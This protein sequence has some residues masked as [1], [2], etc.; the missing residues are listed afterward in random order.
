MYSNVVS[1]YSEDWLHLMEKTIRQTYTICR[2][3]MYIACLNY[4]ECLNYAEWWWQC[5]GNDAARAV[6]DGSSIGGCDSADGSSNHAHLPLVHKRAM[7]VAY[8]V[9]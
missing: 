8:I 3:E 2:G 4:T 6:E 5:T 9:E 1:K 7:M